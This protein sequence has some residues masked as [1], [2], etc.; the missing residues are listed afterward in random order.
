MLDIINHTKNIINDP[1]LDILIN[2][3]EEKHTFCT[4]P[5]SNITQNQDTINNHDS[6]HFKIVEN[7]PSLA[8]KISQDKI[9]LIK[10]DTEHNRNHNKEKINNILNEY[11][12]NTSLIN[13][14][15]MIMKTDGTLK[16]EN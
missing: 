4:F 8:L 12:W 14:N 1:I 11:S 15:D 9:T 2:S 6:T 3:S 16:G 13:I 7:P 5:I 10:H